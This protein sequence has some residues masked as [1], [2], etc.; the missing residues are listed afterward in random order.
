MI[1]VSHL[2]KE[3]SGVRVVDDLYFRSDRCEIIGFLGKNGAGKST[4]MNMMTGYLAA[5]AGSV[6]LC[7]ADIAASPEEAKSHLGYLP[8]FPALYPDLTVQEYLRYACAIKR[9][10]RRSEK[11][12]IDDVC[13]QT[14][15][16]HVRKRLIRNLSKGYRQRVGLAN[17][18]IGN[19]EVIL[20]DEPS[21]GLD[22][23]QNIE[24]R[25]CIRSLGQEH[26]VMLSSHMLSEISQ[27]CDRL[28]IIE[29]GRIVA[30]GSMESLLQGSAGHTH[31]LRLAGDSEAA[32]PC[33]EKIPGIRSVRR[34]QDGLL[35]LQVDRDQEEA[36]F[37]AMFSALYAL[38]SPILELSPVSESLEDVFIRLTGQEEGAPHAGCL[39]V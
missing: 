2:A 28:I 26:T 31:R 12:H 22:P 25:Q 11:A 27:V 16:A 32:V 35:L 6:R 13:E 36:A 4:T 34:A 10:S 14:G 8:E 23:Q 38:K 5:S 9:V 30:Q 33:L 7:G 1:E 21:V 37:G 19:P 24:M 3:Y 20:L 17:A 18:L 15:I 39:S 29:A